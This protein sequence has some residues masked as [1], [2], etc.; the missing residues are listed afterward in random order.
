MVD[1]FEVAPGLAQQRVDPGTL[2][3]DG[4]ALRVVL[5]IGGDE[6]GGGDDVGEI[7]LQC[8]DLR[9]RLGSF[10]DE[11]LGCLHLSIIVRR[12]DDDEVERRAGRASPLDQPAGLCAAYLAAADVNEWL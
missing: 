4:R 11:L 1:R 5:V 9:D 7:C 3:R 2:E 6:F 12:N 10:C 8:L